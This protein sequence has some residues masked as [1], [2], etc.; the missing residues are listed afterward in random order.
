METGSR[1][2]RRFAA[3]IAEPPEK[4]HSKKRAKRLKSVLRQKCSHSIIHNPERFGNRAGFLARFRE[5]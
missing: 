4:F 1:D 3:I 2:N 5:E